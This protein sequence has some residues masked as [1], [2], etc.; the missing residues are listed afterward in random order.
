[1]VS[2]FLHILAVQG[3][4]AIALFIIFGL[5]EFAWWE[6][7]ALPGFRRREGRDASPSP[8]F[9]HPS[10]KRQL[11]QAREAGA[12]HKPLTLVRS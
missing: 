6:V 8:S 4:V 11:P 12:E 1:M 10:V 9:S 3:V 5:I 7:V 2:E